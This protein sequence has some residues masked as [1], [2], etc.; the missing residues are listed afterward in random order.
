MHSCRLGKTIF[1]ALSQS[2]WRPYQGSCNTITTH[3]QPHSEIRKT[4]IRPRSVTW[5]I[6]AKFEFTFQRLQKT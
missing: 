4:H 6:D 5:R 2:R 1:A 3:P